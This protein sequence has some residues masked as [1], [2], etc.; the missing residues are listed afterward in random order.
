MK[1][2]TTISKI[3]PE[4]LNSSYRKNN[5]G[6][7][8]EALAF[9]KRPKLAVEVGVLE[10]YSAFHISKYAEKLILC[11]IFEEFPYHHANREDI[12]TKF[13]HAD[14]V[15]MNFYEDLPTLKDIDLLHV[16]IAND[17]DTFLHF[18]K[19]YYQLLAPGGI[20]LL[21]GGSEER[22]GYWW[23]KAFKKKPIREALQEFD[24]QGVNYHV[25]NAFPS[26][27]IVRK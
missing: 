15:H 12:V 4:Q 5:F 24:A 11:D 13:P 18:L 23:M 22:D 8:F 17:G 10:G 16:D 9:V 20:A 2:I 6:E 25:I 27:T 3:N 1:N 26:L 7:V 14:I 19:F 21:E